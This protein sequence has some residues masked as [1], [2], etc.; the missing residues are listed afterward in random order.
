VRWG[1]YVL[2]VVAEEGNEVAHRAMK[3][4]RFGVLEVQPGQ[5]DSNAERLRAE[6]YDVIGAYGM[7]VEEGL[8]PP[9]DL[10]PGHV[11]AIT[12]AKRAKVEKF[13]VIS[14][15]EGTLELQGCPTPVREAAMMKRAGWR[16]E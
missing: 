15:L 7:A 13:A 4:N 8:A 12:A 11:L 3:A 6:V 2:A 9:L 1:Q 14:V 10:E 16:E 5:L